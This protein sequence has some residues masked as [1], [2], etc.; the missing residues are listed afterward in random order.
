MIPFPKQAPE[1]GSALSKDLTA[2]TA[3][4][5]L[6]LLTGNLKAFV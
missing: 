3:N 2:E 4:Q 6:L 1:N 5:L